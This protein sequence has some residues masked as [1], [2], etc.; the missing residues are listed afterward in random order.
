MSRVIQD[1]AIGET[2]RLLPGGEVEEAPESH[3]YEKGKR[4]GERI[5]YMRARAED[6]AYLEIL[7]TVIQ[8]ILDEKERLFDH[9]RP[10][11]LEFSLI[12]CERVMRQE[13]AQPETLAKM[14]DEH[15]RNAAPTLQGALVHIVLSPEDLAMLQGHLETIHYDKREIRGVRFVPD[16]TMHRGDVR[17][18][19]PTHLL[20]CALTREL[21]DVREKILKC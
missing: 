1:V 2:L 11:L 17:I 4:E 19:T 21:D 6:A 9:L 5:G 15:L 18:E 8:K 3:A 12:L 14:I 13:L 20:N 7:Q 16:P 10:E